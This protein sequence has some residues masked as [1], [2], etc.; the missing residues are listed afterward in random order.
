MSGSNEKLDR[1]VA[2][3]GE[4][5]LRY[6]YV[7][8]TMGDIAKA[9]GM[10]RA[11]LYLLF[12]G[13]EQAFAAATM[14]LAVR[15]L[16]EIR[17]VVASCDGLRDKLTTGCVMLL[18]RVLELQQTTPDARDMDDLAFPVVRE[19]YAMFEAFFAEIITG[20][21]PAPLIPAGTAARALLYGVRGLREVADTPAS[22]TAL[23]EAHVALISDGI[24]GAGASAVTRS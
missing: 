21:A 19:I 23:I 20:S 12:P 1:A 4:V 17:A 16:D 3:A 9:A 22:Y 14:A 5:F 13:K 7:R 15:R 6:G 2:A 10:S 24:Y 11:A 8:T 18:V